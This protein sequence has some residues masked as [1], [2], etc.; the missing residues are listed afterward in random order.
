MKTEAQ[1]WI[2]VEQE[3]PPIGE[4]VEVKGQHTPEGIWWPISYRREA[5]RGLRSHKGTWTWESIEWR[6]TVGITHWRR[7]PYCDLHREQPHAH[8]R[9]DQAK[10]N[11]PGCER[12]LQDY[13]DQYWGSQGR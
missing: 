6:G 7:I 8:V 12:D 4:R 13:S 10:E 3:L 5:M 9:P 11:C 1:E 2:P